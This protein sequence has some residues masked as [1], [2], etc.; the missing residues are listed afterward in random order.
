[1]SGRVHT[2]YLDLMTQTLVALWTR[3]RRALEAAGVEAPVHEARLL[4][5]AGAGVSRLDIVTDPRREMSPAQT[6]GVD[7]LTARRAAREPMA[8]I[9]GRKQF[10]RLDLVV[11][12]DVLIPRPETE[13]VVEAAL[14][15]IAPEAAARVVDLGVGS[16]A[17]L[18][19][20]LSERANAFGVGVDSSAGALTVA[21]A[22]AECAGLTDRA[23]FLGGDWWEGVEGR[24]DVVVSNPPYI[25]TADIAGLAPEV[26]R[27][28]PRLALDGG[29]DG[30]DAYR[31][32]FE[33]LGARLSPG[34]VFVFE[35]GIGQADNVADLASGYGFSTEAP[36]RDLSGI[37]RV[38]VGHRADSR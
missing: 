17:I 15:A 37:A 38:I 22:N 27:F 9:L 26:A 33:G 14:E 23:K 29:T 2:C 6:A 24:F 31:A 35:I 16:G 3:V 18:L 7:A 21:R 20:I 8:H 13:L 4:V 36:R 11:S 1:M 34:G 5:E 10:W 28:E 19:A 12:A 32:I 25:P 30:L